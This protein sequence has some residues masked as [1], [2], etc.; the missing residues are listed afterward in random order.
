MLD[1]DLD[2]GTRR[3]LHEL[4]DE[5]LPRDLYG[6]RELHAIAGYLNFFV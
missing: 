2:E 3:K 4:R 6:V 1:K 5:W